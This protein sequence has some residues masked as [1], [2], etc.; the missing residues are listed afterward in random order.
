MTDA[1]QNLLALNI[2]LALG[3]VI[4]LFLMMMWFRLTMRRWPNRNEV[5]VRLGVNALIWFG[6]N[7]L[8]FYF[9]S[10]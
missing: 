5:L 2:V 7:I 3:I 9:K 8:Y 10:H 6:A 1:A 4:T